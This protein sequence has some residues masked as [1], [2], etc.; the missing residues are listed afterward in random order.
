MLKIGDFSKLSRVSVQALRYYDDLG[1][2]KPVQVDRFSGYRYYSAT[3]LARLNRILALKDLGLSLEQIAQLLKGELPS[4]QLRGMLRLKQAEIEQHLQEEQA[5]LARVAARLKQIEQEAAMSNYDVILK[6]SKPAL[7]ASLRQQLP[8]YSQAGQ[9]IEE[10]MNYVMSQGSARPVG[11]TYAVWHDHSYR[12]QDID[13]EVAVPIT[14][15]VH[16][17]GR[18]QVYQTPL[19]ENM[20]CVI[21]QGRMEEISAAYE[22]IMRWIETNGY[23][24]TGPN[25][26]I[27][28]HW[29][30]PGSDPAAT[31]AE[32]QFPVEKA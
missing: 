32:I 26:E 4:E 20:A 14:G 1:L 5:R 3:Q 31:V 24:I 29:P 21:H 23:Q 8:S 28:L 30:E 7:V 27:Y 9:L 25:R 16:P 2:L 22:A 19:V 10:L 13:A 17:D 11:P 12:E 6:K 15:T 18:I